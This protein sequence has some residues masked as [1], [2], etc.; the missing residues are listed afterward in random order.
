MELIT[1]VGNSSAYCR[2]I[3]TIPYLRPFIDLLRLSLTL[4]PSRS[5]S[6]SLSRGNQGL[7]CLAALAQTQAN[8]C[9]ALSFSSPHPSPPPSFLSSSNSHVLTTSTWSKIQC[10]LSITSL[11]G[12]MSL[13]QKEKERE[14]ESATGE[15]ESDRGERETERGRAWISCE[16]ARPYLRMEC[17]FHIWGKRRSFVWTLNSK[18]HSNLTSLDKPI[19]TPTLSLRI[20]FLP[21]AIGQRPRNY[22]SCCCS[23][24]CCSPFGS[25]PH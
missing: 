13:S 25:F 12:I 19:R 16:R 1:S 15:R 2:M 22:L 21:A 5:L 10:F 8:V 9:A 7:S 18:V 24:C 17:F 11:G 23:S 4:F 14:R 3:A 6:L 20:Y